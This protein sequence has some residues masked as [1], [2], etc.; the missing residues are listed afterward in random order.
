MSWVLVAWDGPVPASADDAARIFEELESSVSEDDPP[1]DAIRGYVEELL[2]RWPDITEDRSE[3]SPW[4]DGPLIANASGPLF[5]FSLGLRSLSESIP[6]CT[7]VARRRGIVLYDQEQEEVYSP[8]GIPAV[9]SA[10]AH[11]SSPRRW[12]FRRR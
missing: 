12:F 5:V 7:E 6:Y 8:A 4:A 10:P 3:D 1:T 11:A 9:V 2:A